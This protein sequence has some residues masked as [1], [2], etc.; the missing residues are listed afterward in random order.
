MR[1][2][3]DDALPLFQHAPTLNKKIAFNVEKK[4]RNIQRLYMC[5]SKRERIWC[6]QSGK[7]PTEEIGITE[8]VKSDSH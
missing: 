1:T 6:T 3:T 7:Q 4:N 2:Y 8:T 5:F